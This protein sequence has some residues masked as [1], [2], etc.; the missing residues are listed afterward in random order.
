MKKRVIIIGG[1][2]AGTMT[3]LALAHDRPELA[4]DILLFES[5]SFP[6]AKICGGGV[7]GRVAAFL[8][9][10][11]VSIEKLPKVPVR[12][13]NIYFDTKRIEVP[14]H[15][16][17]C[18]VVR[19]SA[20]DNLLLQEVRE[21]GIEVRAPLAVTG[22]YR[23]RHG[24]TVLDRAGTS[25]SCQ[26]LVG[27]DGV[28]GKTR[29]WFGKPH[30]ARKTLLLQTDFPRDPDSPIFDDSL[31]LDFSPRLLGRNGYA[32][33]FPSL[34]AEGAPVVNAGITGG[35]FSRGSFRQS[36]EIFLDALDRHPQ[37]KEMARG[38][39]RFRP[40]PEQDFSP[41]HN[42]AGERV[43]LTGEQLGVDS[44]TG[45]GLDIC[46]ASARA[47]AAEIVLA[48]V[49]GDYR[50]RGYP[51]RLLLSD[52]FPLYLIGKPFW[53]ESP[54]PDGPSVLFSMATRKRAPEVENILEIY[55]KIFSGA[56]PGKKVFSPYFLKPVLRDLPPELAVRFWQ[57][58]RPSHP[59]V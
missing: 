17:D 10:L 13:F 28:N 33:F 52:F 46:A 27:A 40:Y 22:A 15:N 53:M 16:D 6:R 43:I 54:G 57:D 42:L 41:F 23:E 50:F 30:L 31:L 8:G 38:N 14:F 36:R 26:I 45:E 21:R 47:A 32:W 34:D 19:R 20:F 55:G 1:G 25:H 51:R 37:I 9:R 39:L 3:A 2:P 29:S 48:L 35:N 12:G 4:R 24:V 18:F 5:R 56:L 44:F 59:T 11:G 49:T 58:H 7:S